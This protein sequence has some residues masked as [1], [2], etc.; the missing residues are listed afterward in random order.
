LTPTATIL[1][2][3]ASMS[4]T[5]AHLPPNTAPSRNDV[6]AFGYR[7]HLGGP[8]DGELAGR[9][10]W[11][12]C[13]PGWDGVETSPDDFDTEEQAWQDAGAAYLLECA[14]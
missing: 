3:S 12:L 1:T 9:W 2:A 5:N 11:S 14:P 8:D 7:V 6:E 13:Q 10:W 4:Q